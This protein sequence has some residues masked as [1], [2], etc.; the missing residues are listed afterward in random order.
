MSVWEAFLGA[1]LRRSS[2]AFI[3][4]SHRLLL[5]RDKLA[6]YRLLGMAVLAIVFHGRAAQ[7]KPAVIQYIATKTLLTFRDLE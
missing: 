2:I 1:A 7:R 5:S 6:H 3:A 4:Y